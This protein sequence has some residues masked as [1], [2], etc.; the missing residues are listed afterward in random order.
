[1]QPTIGRVV[2]YKMTE[3]DVLQHK[4]E[5]NGVQPGEVVPAMISRVFDSSVDGNGCCNLRL[6]PDGRCT[7][8]RTSVVR[9]DEPGQWNWPPRV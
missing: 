8:M 4:D 2:H 1:M 6:L 7:P 3:S 5:L 9:G